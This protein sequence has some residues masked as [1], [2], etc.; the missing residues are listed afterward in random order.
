MSETTTVPDLRRLLNE[1]SAAPWACNDEPLTWVG[2]REGQVWS[3]PLRESGEFLDEVADT[4]EHADA[5]LIVALRNAAPALLTAIKAVQEARRYAHHERE[6]S[7]FPLSFG[8][9]DMADRL[10]AALALLSSLTTTGASS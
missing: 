3:V 10:D 9:G 6:I 1:A 4:C 7:S 8:Y 5:A 2:G